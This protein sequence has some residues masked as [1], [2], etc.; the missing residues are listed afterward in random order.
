MPSIIKTI[1]QYMPDKRVLDEKPDFNNELAQSL[2][3]KGSP[4]GCITLHGIGGTPAN[5][6]VVS[7]A[8]IAQNFTVLAPMLPGHGETLRIFNTSTGEQWLDCVFG[9]YDLLKA[10]G[11]TQILAFGLSLGAILAC[12]LAESRPLAGLM[13][14]CAPVKMPTYLHVA[15]F[16]SPLLPVVRFPEDDEDDATSWRNDPHAQMYDG[17]STVKLRDLKRL[18]RRLCMNLENVSCP[19]FIVQARH[20]DKVLPTS[21]DT[22]RKGMINA[23]TLEFLELENSPHGCTYG[24]ERDRVAT[25][26]ADFANRITVPGD[27]C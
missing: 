13:M 20:D 2:F 14:M 25:L 11:C 5:V 24:P 3:H 26:A 1:A 19:V 27:C 21:F 4:I 8:L 9:A 15:R 22:L 10:E 6:R 16:I 12:L 17:F 23:T 7:D 18:N